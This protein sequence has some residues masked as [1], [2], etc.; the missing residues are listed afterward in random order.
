[1]IPD[2]SNP[3]FDFS[4]FL[5]DEIPEPAA[6]TSRSQMNEPWNSVAALNTSGYN[7][8]GF[9]CFLPGR[10]PTPPETGPTA[11]NENT[12]KETCSRSS[13]RVEGVQR[14]K[15]RRKVAQR[16]QVEP[17]E[18][19]WEHNFLADGSLQNRK[20]RNKQN[21]DHCRGR[22]SGPLSLATAK[23]AVQVRKIG[24]CWRCWIQHVPVRLQN[25]IFLPS[26]G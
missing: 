23:K 22:R 19:Q 3:D 2:L 21:K 25:A 6:S 18:L 10:E 16:K 5:N 1:M 8:A 7:G 11:R 26:P 4:A 15:P 12:Q 20:E 24:A 14:H 17:K 13:R 9:S